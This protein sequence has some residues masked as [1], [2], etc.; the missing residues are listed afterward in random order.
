MTDGIQLRRYVNIIEKRRLRIN[1]SLFGSEFLE[2]DGLDGFRRKQ[3]AR[4][5]MC[6]Y[7]RESDGSEYVLTRADDGELLVVVF[8]G[9]EEHRYRVKDV[10]S[11]PEIWPCSMGLVKAICLHNGLNY[12]DALVD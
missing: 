3:V 9:S 12:T 2:T 8:Y 4:F 10:L 1:T 11:Y 6:F 5:S 7:F